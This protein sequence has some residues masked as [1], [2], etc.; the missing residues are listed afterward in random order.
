M[1]VC[2][3][4]LQGSRQGHICKLCQ[5]DFVLSRRGVS[6]GSPPLS[7]PRGMFTFLGLTVA[8]ESR[9]YF[10]AARFLFGAEESNGCR[11]GGK[12]D[13]TADQMSLTCGRSQ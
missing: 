12:P 3:L 5:N 2:Q 9:R 1:E 4:L 11:E 7:L 13:Q 8:G 10:E 6:R